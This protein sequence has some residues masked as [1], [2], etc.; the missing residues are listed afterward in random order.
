[1]IAHRLTGSRCRCQACGELFNSVSV[2]T[3]HRVGRWEKRGA[4]R[5]CLTIP[6]MQVRGWHVNARGF[7]IERQRLDQPRRGGD[8]PPPAPA[9]RGPA[10]TVLGHAVA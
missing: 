7:W 6:Q 3:R 5:R 2:F 9:P 4:L 8:L 10:A 1:M